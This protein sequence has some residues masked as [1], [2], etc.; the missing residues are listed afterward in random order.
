MNPYEVLGVS[1]NATDDEIKRAYRELIKKY[2]PDSYEGNPLS[3]LAEEKFRQVQ[4]AYDQIMRERSYGGG[5]YGN[6]YGGS[7]G[8]AG[9]NY[10]EAELQAVHNYLS[11]S[12]YGEAL[13]EL[14]RISNRTSRWFYYSAIANVGL[15]NTMRGMEHARTALN[16]EPANPDYQSLVNQ[17]SFQN[18]R[19]N[20]VRTNY[21][22]NNRGD[23]MMD[24]CCKLWMAD[25]LCE[26]L[27]G[28]L[29]SC[30]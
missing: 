15:G 17:L 3:S 1:R 27:G 26:C 21:S 14:E 29:C 16:M 12:R 7:Y 23:D 18:Q 28:D 6:S 24:M 30:M 22:Y 19:Y 5:N 10:A 25:T 20:N 13:R 4:G 9:G 11:A 8:N 2:H